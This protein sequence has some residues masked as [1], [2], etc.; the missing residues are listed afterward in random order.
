MTL[1]VVYDSVIAEN[2]KDLAAK[3]TRAIAKGWQLHGGIQSVYRKRQ[4]SYGREEGYSEYTQFLVLFR[5]EKKED[6]PKAKNNKG[7]A[8]TNEKEFLR[9]G[10]TKRRRNR[11][12]RT[13]RH[14]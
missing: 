5:E 10:Y 7:P 4:I 8:A 9:A 11:K 6:A 12:N 14:Y 3:A 2:L 1:V 13:R